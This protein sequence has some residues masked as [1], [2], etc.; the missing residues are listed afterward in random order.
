MKE[1]AIQ[2]SEINLENDT[3]TLTTCQ[4]K[5]CRDAGDK[6]CGCP[7]VYPCNSDV[8][9]GPECNCKPTRCDRSTLDEGDKRP[10]ERS[11]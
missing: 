5:K 11:Q 4:C 3:Q 1:V 9:V 7:V 10:S 8:K 6:D 2:L